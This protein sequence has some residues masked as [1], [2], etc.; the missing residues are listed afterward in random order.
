M[1]HTGG[2]KEAIWLRRL[3]ADIQ[4]MDNSEPTKL[5]CDNQSAIKLSENHVFHD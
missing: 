3:L 2:A 1:A 4:I 5:M